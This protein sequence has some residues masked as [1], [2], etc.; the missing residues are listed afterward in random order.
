MTDPYSIDMSALG[1]CFALDIAAMEDGHE[2]KTYIHAKS[3]GLEPGEYAEM[4]AV[5]ARTRALAI[6]D[7]HASS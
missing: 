6:E 5:F 1:R 4:L 3:V 2:P 7:G